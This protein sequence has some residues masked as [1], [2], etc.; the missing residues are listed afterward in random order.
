MLHIPTAP[1]AFVAVNHEVVGVVRPVLGE[2]RNPGCM[3]HYAAHIK[4]APMNTG[5]C[6]AI[7]P[8]CDHKGLDPKNDGARGSP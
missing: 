8:I 3:A 4:L 7:L 1:S 2:A 5:L 6:A